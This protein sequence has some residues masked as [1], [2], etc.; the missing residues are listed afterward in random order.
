MKAIWHD[1]EQ[2][3]DEWLNL[4]CGV[5]NS[6]SMAK[7]MANFGKAFSE[8]AKKYAADIAAMKILGRP[9]SDS[10]YK[11]SDMDRGHIQE[12]FA[13][14]AYELQTFTEVTNGSFYSANK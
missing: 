10:G 5:I 3:T 12:P 1:V 13:K 4:R 14:A 11:N 9:L 8:P 7:V 6:S 2:N